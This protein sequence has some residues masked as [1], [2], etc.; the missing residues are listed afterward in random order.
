MINA[1]KEDVDWATSMATKKAV[2]LHAEVGYVGKAETV[3][4]D[5]FLGDLVVVFEDGNRF[6]V[7]GRADFTELTPNEARFLTA[8]TGVMR[9]MLTGTVAL[10]KALGV[11]PLRGALIVRTVVGAQ[12]RALGGGQ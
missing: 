8:F 9:A 6:L 5:P 3:E 11:A 12:L 2:L 4:A 7:R 10:G 1:T